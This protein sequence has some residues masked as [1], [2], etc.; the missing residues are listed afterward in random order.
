MGLSGALGIASNA[1]EVFSTG[2][3]VTGQNIANANTPGYIQEQL[4]LTPAPD[5]T[6]G[7]L[8]LGTGVEAVGVTQQ[9]NQFLQGEILS[10]NSNY[11]AS[12][13]LNTVYTNLQ[14]ELQAL[15]TNSL[16][17][18]MS[19]FTSALNALANQPNSSSLSAAAVNAGSSLANSISSLR[20]SIDEQRQQANVSVQQ[21][22]TQA[23]QLTASGSPG[24]L[25][26]LAAAYAAAG[27][28]SNAVTTADLARQKAESGRF[29]TMT[30]NLQNDLSFYHAGK[31]A[32]L[33]WRNPPIRMKLARN[34][35]IPLP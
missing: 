24:Y 3:Q 11:N 31:T 26:T 20:S 13:T 15:G 7:P 2:I 4:S 17:S 5:Y 27:S 35:E 30:T 33:D 19:N 16:S 6:V 29:Q 12:N 18:Q 21:L 1:L 25:R 23:N 14:Q 8:S 28:F 9:V 34:N 22:A 32:P 10:A